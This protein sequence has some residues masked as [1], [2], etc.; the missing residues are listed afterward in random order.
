MFGFRKLNLRGKLILILLSMALLTLL[1]ATSLFSY[2]DLSI[3]KKNLVRH[4]MA[5]ADSAGSMVR[6]ALLF[7]DSKRGNE[8]FESL[9]RREKQIEFAALYDAKGD[10]FIQYSRRTSSPFQSP[11]LKA[12]KYDFID[13]H[14]EISQDIFLY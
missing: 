9:L 7:E 11:S 12:Q 10:P 4:N 1:V 13:G 8:I 14:V 5:I 6:A 3:F 2:N